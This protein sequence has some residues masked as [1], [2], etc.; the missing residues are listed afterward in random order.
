MNISSAVVK[1]KNINNKGIIE[2]IEAIKGSEVPLISGQKLIVTIEAENIAEETAI[3]KKIESIAGVIS[4]NLVYAYNEDELEKE[5]EKVEQASDYP[6]WL[7]DENA[8]ANKIPY[9]GKLNI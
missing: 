9:S 3:M 4:I 8:K 7:N 1:T 6:T 2:Q 5:M